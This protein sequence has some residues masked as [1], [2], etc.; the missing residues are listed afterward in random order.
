M[1]LQVIANVNE[2]EQRFSVVLEDATL[3]PEQAVG[4]PIFSRKCREAEG[5]TAL[6]PFADNGLTDT[7]INT[8]A[9]VF[10]RI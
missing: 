2:A 7:G 4:V 10:N 8:S 5:Q 3:S 6:S 9:A 1:Q